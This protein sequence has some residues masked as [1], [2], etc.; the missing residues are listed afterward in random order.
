MY[1][2]HFLVTLILSRVDIY[3]SYAFTYSGKSFFW[4]SRTASRWVVN[5]VPCR[6]FVKKSAI[7][8]PVG[9]YSTL[10]SLPLMLSVTKKYLILM[11]RDALPTDL[12]PFSS[13]GMAL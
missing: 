9:K 12:M 3:F 2:E 7:I 11:C 6:G 8:F 4:I 10:I 1:C 5:G 13:R